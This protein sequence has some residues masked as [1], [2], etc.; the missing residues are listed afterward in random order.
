VIGLALVGIVLAAAPSSDLVEITALDPTVRLDVRYA[1]ADNF[2]GKPLYRVARGFLQR[3]VAEALVRV[4]RALAS[5]GYGLVV[6]DAYRPWSVTKLMWELTPPGQRGFVANPARGSNHNRGCAVDLTLFAIDTGRAV[7]MP[8][9]YDE[10]SPRSAS[11]YPGGSTES[12]ARRDGLRAAMEG[13]GFQVEAH[14]WWHF[15]HRS[16][17]GYEVL[18]LPLESLPA[19][20]A[21]R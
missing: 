10:M 7:E 19:S 14:E 15:N 16:C 18:D 4:H 20:R 21:G 5:Q 17:L 11:A 3:P 12:R 2:L 8:S 6:F 13:Q 9:G 1:T